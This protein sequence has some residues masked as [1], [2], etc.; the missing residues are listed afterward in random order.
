MAINLKDPNVHKVR[1]DLEDQG[2]RVILIATVVP[3][4]DSPDG[5]EVRFS[6]KAIWPAGRVWIIEEIVNAA[7]E[8]EGG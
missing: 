1:Q 5:S 4:A 7:A 2:A 8:Q 3:T 6:L